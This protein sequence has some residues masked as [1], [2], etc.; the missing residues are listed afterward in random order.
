MRLADARR[1]ADEQRV[2]GLRG[3]LRDSQGGGVGQTVAVADHEL[4]ERELGIGHPPDQRI[5]SPAD[6]RRTI[7]AVVSISQAPSPRRL[8]RGATNG[9]RGCLGGRAAVREQLDYD[10]L[11]EDALC[12]GLQSSPEAISHPP[13]RLRGNLDD[14]ALVRGIADLQ[15]LKPDA[16]SRLADGACELCLH[17][18]PYVLLLGTHGSDNPLLSGRKWDTTLDG[19]PARARSGDYIQPPR[20]QLPAARNWREKI[21]YATLVHPLRPAALPSVLY[22]SLLFRRGWLPVG[23]GRNTTLGTEQRS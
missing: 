16:V 5:C 19:G 3:H 17:A 14:E 15:G 12:T 20:A 1:P 13:V 6:P 8:N 11:P 21:H 22:F 9:G 10:A 7:V 18:R 2:V 23:P 4:I